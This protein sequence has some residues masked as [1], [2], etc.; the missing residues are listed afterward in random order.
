[1]RLEFFMALMTDVMT[2]DSFI[3]DAFGKITVVESWNRLKKE[4]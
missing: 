2:V 3:G 4:L 1:M